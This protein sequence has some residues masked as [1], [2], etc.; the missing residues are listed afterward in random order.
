MVLSGVGLADA[1]SQG[2]A[3]I[4]P[5]VREIKITAVIETVHQG[6]ILLIATAMAETNQV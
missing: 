6:F 3:A 2:E 4:Q 1:E 5:R